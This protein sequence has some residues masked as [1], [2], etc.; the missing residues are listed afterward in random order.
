[1]PGRANMTA[2]TGTAGQLL[3]GRYQLIAPVGK[4]SM[5]QVWR[6]RD[7]VLSREVAVKEVLLPDWLSKAERDELVVRAM[8]EARAAARLHHPGIVTVYDAVE[9]D[10]VPWQVMEFISSP[11]LA[12]IIAQEGR[13]AWE[14]VAALG[15]HLADAIAHAHA[16]GVV[17]RDVKPA[18]VLLAG[19]R[20]ILTDFGIAC[21]LDS[22]TQLTR[23]GAIIGTP[24]YMPPEQIEGDSRQAPVDLW[25]LGAT[26]YHAVEGCPPFTAPATSGVLA[27]VL[28]QQVPEPRFAG[29]LAPVLHSLLIK[30]PAQ[31]PNAVAL[32]DQLTALL[33]PGRPSLTA[34]SSNGKP[35]PTATSP[36]DRESPC[37]AAV[38]T[39]HSGRVHSVAFSPDGSALASGC[40]QGISADGSLVDGGYRVRLWNPRTQTCRARLAGPQGAAS[41]VAFSPDGTMLASGNSGQ[42]VYLWRIGGRFG[43][44]GAALADDTDV[45][46]LAFSPDGATLATGNCYKTVR[47]WHLN[48]RTCIGVLSGH[49]GWVHS[50]AFS[51]D[52]GMLATGS[53]DRTVQL[54]DVSTQARVA[55]LTGHSEMVRE[56]AFTPDGTLLA[57]C[58]ADKTIRLWKVGT[59]T[60]VATLTAETSSVFC[61]AFSPDGAMLASGGTDNLV[62]LWDIARL[63]CTATL[64]GH[65]EAVTALAFSPDG[66]TLASSSHDKTVRL[67]RL[68]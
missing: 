10:G 12:Q 50:V 62:R 27:A 40:D 47:L 58:S 24:H 32:T 20:A 46:S 33:R 44:K 45:M 30:A 23:T 51:P 42:P 15:A 38:L 35:P 65:S 4:G 17:H 21:I 8:R 31:R 3:G 37:R 7:E 57:S 41:S 13:L 18:N 34:K 16:A 52:G 63:T 36:A 5:G 28:T 19:P 67:W 22:S 39:G 59:R 55:T 49:G 29:P 25:A 1:M 61:V 26:L 11:S 43:R 53:G 9:Y 6:G 2:V 54:W 68:N 60:H 14:R 64:S 56:V 66:T 48:T